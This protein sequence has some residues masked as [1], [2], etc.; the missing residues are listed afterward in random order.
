M[1]PRTGARRVLLL[2]ALDS[3]VA[4]KPLSE[5]NVE[6]IAAEAGITR[7]RFYFY[8]DSKYDALAASL[9]RISDELVAA[10]LATGSWWVRPP[11]VRPRVALS[12]GFNSILGVWRAHG[13]ML[14]EGQDL[15]SAVPQVREA[16]D[17]FFDRLVELTSARIDSERACGLA[18][19][20]PNS[21]DLAVAL[22]WGGER[23]LTLWLVESRHALTETAMFDTLVAEWMRTI[24][25]VDDPD[26]RA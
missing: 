10:Y 20:G 25:L 24:Y 4:R 16:Y 8:F 6:D 21:R 13:P 22:L 15:W 1:A 3:L 17:S 7:T 5:V 26:P 18:P 2:D 14:R 19:A 11:D 23:V 9:N 12:A